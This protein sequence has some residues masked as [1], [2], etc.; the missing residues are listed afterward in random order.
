MKGLRH[1]FLLYLFLF[2]A[3]SSSPKRIMLVSDSSNVAYSQLEEANNSIIAGKYSR[4]YNLLSSGYNLALSVDN[5]DLLCKILLSGIVYK[6]SSP[7]KS[8]LPQG[9]DSVSPAESESFLLQHKESLLSQAKKLA[10]R[11][12]SKKLL[13]DLCAVYDV[14]IRLENEKLA[15]NGRIDSGKKN[16]WLS[17]LDDVQPGVSKE[18][19]YHAY[20]YRTKG[21]VCMA[22]GDYSLA[23]D[24]YAEAAKIHTKERYLLEIGL[25]W[26]C[27]ARAC[28]LGGKK[29]EALS[30]IQTALKY[31]K[32]AENSLGIASDYLACSKIL[33][34]GNPSEE[35]K[36][37]SAELALWS[38]K[39]LRAGGLLETFSGVAE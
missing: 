30:A 7:E 37:L 22:G 14:R 29:S 17:V 12:E 26:Y 21:D 33:L 3:C 38:E 5:T 11:S 10:G 9:S 8:S 15:E 6:I 32:D 2:I 1:F 35:D 13:S 34:K 20:L 39:I 23:Q 25:D 16:D 24:Y 36:K 18:S 4:A 27:L 28:S 19:Y 31:D